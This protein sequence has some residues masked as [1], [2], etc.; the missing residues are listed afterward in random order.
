VRFVVSPSTLTVTSFGFFTIKLLARH[1]LY[2][3]R[4]FSTTAD[5]AGWFHL[6]SVL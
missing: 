5:C 4:F 2:V 3:Q 1:V 6:M